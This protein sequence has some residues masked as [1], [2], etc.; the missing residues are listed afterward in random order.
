MIDHT[1]DAGEA[2]PAGISF[3]EK[4]LTIWVALCILAGIA[5]GHLL[6]A[7]F[8]VIAACA[9]RLESHPR[10]KWV[11]VCFKETISIFIE[12]H[13]TRRTRSHRLFP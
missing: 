13:L 4:Y 1:I 9:D 7:V 8:G 6:P 12:I 5:L 2:A 10:N 11:A 3:F